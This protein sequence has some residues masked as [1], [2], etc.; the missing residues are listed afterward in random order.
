MLFDYQQKIKQNK[1]LGSRE[2]LV[3]LGR[4][5]GDIQKKKQ[6]SDELLVL[7]RSYY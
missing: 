3:T 2:L 5:A 4:C 6:L 1:L 7:N